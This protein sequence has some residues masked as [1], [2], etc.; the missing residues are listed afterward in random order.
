MHRIRSRVYLLVKTC[1]GW[2]NLNPNIMGLKKMFC[3]ITFP[4][5]PLDLLFKK[6]TNRFFLYIYK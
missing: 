4:A 1:V 5:R 2:P 3:F 6:K